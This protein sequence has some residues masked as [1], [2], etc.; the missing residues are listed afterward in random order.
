MRRRNAREPEEERS[1]ISRRRRGSRRGVTFEERDICCAK[2]SSGGS[3][4]VLVVLNGWEGGKAEDCGAGEVVV[5]VEAGD[6]VW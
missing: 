3:F 5:E 6:M 2:C 4:A 1:R